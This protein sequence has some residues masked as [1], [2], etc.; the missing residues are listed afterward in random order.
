MKIK[1]INRLDKNDDSIYKPLVKQRLIVLIKSKL[2][3][4]EGGEY[5][6]TLKDYNLL[7]SNS[8]LF[9]IIIPIK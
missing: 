4:I 6:C 8:G 7:K 2:E 9:S 5:D 3:D 1:N